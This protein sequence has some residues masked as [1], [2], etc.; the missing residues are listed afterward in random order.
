[1]GTGGKRGKKKE[2]PKNRNENRFDQSRSGPR[3]EK[4]E[5]R[6]GIHIVKGDTAMKVKCG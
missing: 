5:R 6:V 3:K 1:V 4:R 2:N